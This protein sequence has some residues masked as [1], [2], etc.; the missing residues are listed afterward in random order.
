MVAAS[1][2]DALVA[3]AGT[4]LLGNSTPDWHHEDLGGKLTSGPYT[5]D[6]IMRALDRKKR[7]MK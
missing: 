6:D 3:T 5:S 2:L 7:E 4:K 1:I